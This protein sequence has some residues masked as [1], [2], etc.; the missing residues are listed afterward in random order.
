[1]NALTPPVHL[2]AKSSK[3]PNHPHYHETYVGHLVETARI[4]QHLVDKHGHFFLESLGLAREVWLEKL[5]RAVTLGAFLHDVGKANH[6][7]QRLVYDRSVYDRSVPPQAF[8]HE[9]MSLLLA[10]KWKPVSSIIE[11]DDKELTNASLFAIAG[12]HLK[13]DDLEMQPREGSGDS[14]VVL[15]TGHSDMKELL[16]RG[17]ELFSFPLPSEHMS[18]IHVDLFGDPMKEVREWLLRAEV[19]WSQIN[20]ALKNFVALVKA[21]VINSDIVASAVLRERD[22]IA[23]VDSVLGRVCSRDELLKVAQTALG[24]N[25]PRVFQELAAKTRSRVTLIRAG[26]GTGKTVAAYLWAAEKA[27]GRKVFFCYPTTGTTTQGYEDYALGNIESRLIHSRSEVDLERLRETRGDE[28]DPFEPLMRYESLSAWDVPVIVATADTVLGI[29]QNNRRSLFSF[30]S[31]A[32]GAFV[33]DEV[34]AYDDRLFGSLLRFMATFTGPPI[35][36]MTASLQ[37]ERLMRI[38]EVLAR[39]GEQMSVVQGPEEFEQVKRYTIHEIEISDPW[40]E[41]AKVIRR[42]GKVLWVANTVERARAIWEKASREFEPILY[43]SRYRYVDRMS[44]HKSVIDSFEKEGAT[45]AVTTQVCEVSLDISADMLVTD[46][47]P[48][49]ALI[50]RMGRVNRSTHVD[51]PKPI[52]IVDVS[53]PEPY[54]EEE[55]VASRKWFNELI[56]DM[57]QTISQADLSSKFIS[58]EES[59]GKGIVDSSWL[60]GGPFSR[61]APL[62]KEGYTVSV[63]MQEDRWKCVGEDGRAINS[64]VKKC[65]IPMPFWPVMQELPKWERLNGVFVAP[66]GRIEYSEKLGGMWR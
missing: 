26:C 21:L 48:V 8:R 65:S 2:L 22:P 55:I 63:V 64:E 45:L 30:P 10:L 52:H 20:D 29:I 57:G 5:E 28:V 47:A 46:L 24:E 16:K 39:Q 34:H 32:N 38:K 6:Q 36:V 9:F 40:E 35:L 42:G 50:Q 53:K 49:P 33:F 25:R 19:W 62:R 43:H 37:Q 1:L 56:K 18:D 15:Y 61:L 7:F 31:I 23:W 60:D 4:A 11:G 58:Y 66:R 13:F 12:H 51:R 41:V 59:D 54:L 27:N 3:T 44:H 17:N 14:S